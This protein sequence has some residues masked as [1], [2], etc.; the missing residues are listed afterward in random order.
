M[1]KLTIDLINDAVS[2]TNT[3]KEREL[4]L[5]DNKIPI[6]QNLGVTAD[7]YATIDLTN[8][9]LAKIDATLDLSNLP[10]LETLL[11][12]NN[13][14]T[15]LFSSAGPELGWPKKVPRLESLVLTDNK[16]GQ[17]L[18]EE[19]ADLPSSSI[20]TKA[21]AS[22]HVDAIKSCLDLDILDALKGLGKLKYLSLIGNPVCEYSRQISSS[23]GGISF[24]GGMRKDSKDA[25]LDMSSKIW[26][27]Y[28]L[29][30][31]HTLPNL[32]YLDFRHIKL[33]EREKAK[34]LFA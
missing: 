19:L 2:F 29:Y 1:V 6:L 22:K 13:K 14:L 18:M 10:H 8:N 27:I 26:D 12:A 24:C 16:I 20:T 4:D 30:I 31:I 32:K 17:A 9:D 28:R 5:R 25:E 34:K 33:E 15:R 11:L 7:Q 23:K 21:K 3:L